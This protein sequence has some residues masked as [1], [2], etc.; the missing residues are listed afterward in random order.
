MPWLPDAERVA[1]LGE[2][3]SNPQRLNKTVAKIQ[4]SKLRTSC[5]I[6][7]PESASKYRAAPAIGGPPI[8]ARSGCKQDHLRRPRSRQVRPG[9][10]RQEVSE[11]FVGNHSGLFSDWIATSE[12]SR[13]GRAALVEEYK[14]RRRS[15]SQALA[16][17]SKRPQSRSGPRRAIKTSGAPSMMK[18]TSAHSRHSLASLKQ[19]VESKRLA[20]KSSEL[21]VLVPGT[22]IKRSELA[23]LQKL[24]GF[25][26]EDL[27]AV[28]RA[29]QAH[30]NHDPVHNA[31]TREHFAEVMGELFNETTP[32]VMDRLFVSMD[33]D[34]SGTI[35]YKELV[36]GCAK[37]MSRESTDERFR[38]I[39]DAYDQDGSGTISAAELMRL[40]HE[41]G[42]ELADSLQVV[43][44]V[45]AL[46]DT[47]GT[48]QLSFSDFMKAGQHTQILLDAFEQLLPSPV[49]L[50]K[51]VE[52]LN[53]IPPGGEFIKCCGM[54]TRVL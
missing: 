27:R 2:G 16:R 50:R 3:T 7:Y 52:D 33:E 10:I 32:Q 22:L 11:S 17:E 21:V 19:Q 5:Q 54:Q 29:F 38:L 45:L 39:F 25:R 18:R 41:K 14:Q 44:N 49:V 15:R 1:Q 13:Q 8:L 40:V 6:N 31:V 35:D 43:T 28:M 20:R 26:C 36:K 9:D 24:S 12:R 48:G 42:V 37:L 46:L 34:G 51:H 30:T 23:E 47:D 4:L 53:A